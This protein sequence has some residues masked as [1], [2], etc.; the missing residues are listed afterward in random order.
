MSIYSIRIVNF[1]GRKAKRKKEKIRTARRAGVI[2][3]GVCKWI[4]KG[5][6]L[7]QGYKD[8]RPQEPKAPGTQEPK[9]SR[10]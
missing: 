2:K 8:I 10:I 3:N 6:N 5:Y 4:W 1:Q 9:N 7:G